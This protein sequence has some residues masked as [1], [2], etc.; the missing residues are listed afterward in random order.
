MFLVRIIEFFDISFVRTNCF[1]ILWFESQLIRAHWFSVSNSIILFMV[2]YQHRFSYVFF[3]EWFEIGWNNINAFPV[4]VKRVL[5]V[6]FQN[7]TNVRLFL[8]ITVLMSK[9]WCLIQTFFLSFL[10]MNIRISRRYGLLIH[11][12]TP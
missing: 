7:F 5:K 3:M 6:F 12:H 10:L 4:L 11:I 1:F 2:I 9:I 8:I